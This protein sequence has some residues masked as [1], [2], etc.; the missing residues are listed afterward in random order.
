MYHQSE[1]QRRGGLDT[2]TLGVDIDLLTLPTSPLPDISSAIAV[3][4]VGY[5]IDGGEQRGYLRGWGKW[6]S[7]RQSG[8]AAE[9]LRGQWRRHLECRHADGDQQHSL[10]QQL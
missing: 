7:H 9:R 4:G 6:Q 3:E 5:A 10:Q 1:H 8:H 2:I